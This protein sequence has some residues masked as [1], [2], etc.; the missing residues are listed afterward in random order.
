MFSHTFLKNYDVKVLKKSV[1]IA[2][3]SIQ[4]MFNF[5]NVLGIN[6]QEKCDTIN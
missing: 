1:H 4:L 6:F 2:I 5:K 3:I